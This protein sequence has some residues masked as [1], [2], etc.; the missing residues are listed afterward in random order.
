S[1]STGSAT[2][3]SVWAGACAVFDCR[4]H[5]PDPATTV[6]ITRART[7]DE[8]SNR[9]MMG[10]APTHANATVEVLAGGQR[11]YLDATRRGIPI[12]RE[13]SANAHA[14]HGKGAA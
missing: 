14:C 4:I 3:G 9:F 2:A 6:T 11:A 8:E 7:N 5:A 10:I 12:S 13:T 1:A